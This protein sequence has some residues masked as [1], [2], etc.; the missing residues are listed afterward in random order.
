MAQ[1]HAEEIL[2]KNQDDLPALTIKMRLLAESGNLDETKKI[3]SKIPDK[4][5]DTNSPYYKAAS[6]I[7]KTKE[8]QEKP[9]K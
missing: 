7:L 5:K 4:V 8:I 9:D 1:G 2:N 6:E 3:A